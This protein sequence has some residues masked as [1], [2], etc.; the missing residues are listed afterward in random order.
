M[1][2]CMLCCMGEWCKG[3]E[4]TVDGRA[5]KHSSVDKGEAAAGRHLLAVSLTRTHDEQ[6][7]QQSDLGSCFCRLFPRKT[8]PDLFSHA[9]AAVVHTSASLSPCC[10]STNR[11]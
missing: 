8:P 2:C 6:Q 7:Q 9:V 10:C 11:Q 3:A 1:A 5:D 4:G